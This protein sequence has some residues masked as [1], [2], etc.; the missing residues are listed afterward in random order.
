MR[1]FR[2]K[3]VWLLVLVVIACS[4]VRVVHTDAAPGFRLGNYTSFSFYE[5]ETAG[6]ATIINYSPTFDYLKS[7]LINQLES[8]G[9]RHTATNPDLRINLG[10]VV[11]EEVQT[12][13][14][15]FMTDRPRY[16]GQQRYSWRSEEV[17]VDRY[18]EG[19]ISIHLVD[20]ERGEMLW[21]GEAEAVVPDDKKKL[22]KRINEGVRELL[23]KM[24]Q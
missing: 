4:P 15:D 10:I 2:K 16:M 11:V 13:E 19:T 18:K 9:L 22:Q 14:T 23:E 3:Y 12:R 6:D 17:V 20:P 21:Q 7:A 1:K 5:T 24:P 8:R